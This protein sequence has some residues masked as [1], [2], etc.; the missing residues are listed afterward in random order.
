[1]S[2]RMFLW[3]SQLSVLWAF[4]SDLER[5]FKQYCNY[6]LAASFDGW[7]QSE[8]GYGNPGVYARQWQTASRSLFFF[9]EAGQLIDGPQLKFPVGRFVNSWLEKKYDNREMD[10]GRSGRLVWILFSMDRNA[11]PWLDCRFAAVLY[12]PIPNFMDNFVGS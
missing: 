4:G 10:P 5:H 6:I 12:I 8:R 9:W 2:C 11:T 3:Q 1:M 7:L